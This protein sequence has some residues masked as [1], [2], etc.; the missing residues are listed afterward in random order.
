MAKEVPVYQTHEF[1]PKGTKYC[2]IIHIW[3][4]GD[5]IRNQLKRMKPRAHEADII[6]AD[7]DSQDGSTEHEFLKSMDVRALLVT[8]EIGLGTAIRVGLDYAIEE[9][10]EGVITVDGNGKDGVEA[11]TEFIECLE[12]GYDFIQGSRYLKGGSYKNTPLERHIGVKYIISPI[13][14]LM[15][16]KWFS[17]V[18]NGFRAMSMRFLKDDRLQ[19]LR[20]ELQRFNL[21]F[22]LV[23]RAPK[24]KMKIKEIAV[25]RDY[26]DS[27][28]VP[29]KITKFKTKLRLFWEMTRTVFGGYNP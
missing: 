5:R 29:T 13:Y 8:K 28:E 16:G 4:E 20:H 15:T 14:L 21:Q 3:N 11:I 27:G 9:G 1:R 17:D 22:Y 23:Y 24:L 2:V 12:E 25:I 6:I 19:P 10:Y 26:P 7:G 18:T